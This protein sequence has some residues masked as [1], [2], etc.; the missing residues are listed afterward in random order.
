MCPGTIRVLN[1]KSLVSAIKDKYLSISNVFDF[2]FIHCPCVIMYLN[3]FEFLFSRKC[4]HLRNN[5]LTHDCVLFL[6]AEIF[7]LFYQIIKN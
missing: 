1:T 4:V 6:K 3:L 7:I 5:I 2:S